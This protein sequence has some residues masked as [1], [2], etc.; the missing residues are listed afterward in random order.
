MAVQFQ[1]KNKT[2]PYLTFGRFFPKQILAMVSDRSL[3]FSR[4]SA[5]PEVEQKRDEFFREH[6]GMGREKIFTINQVHGKQV[7]SLKRPEL[8]SYREI[9]EA[10]GIIT[11][12]I[13]LPLAIRTADCLSLF[14]F[15]P[16]NAVIAL[17]HAGWRGTKEGI[18]LQALNMMNNEWGSSPASL[19]VAL[20]P[21]LRSCCYRV[22]RE[23][24][25][26]FPRET[27]SKIDGHYLDLPQA[28]LNQLLDHGIVESN[29][30]DCAI[31]T[32]CDERFFSHRREG[33]KTGRM[34]S[35]MMLKS[36]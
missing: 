23:F 19:K 20:G 1:S 5:D 15:D 11:K 24:K 27:L 35:L 36:S 26:Y 12:E 18:V 9:Q 3:N 28:N 6:L 14:I 8:N 31:C 30:F 2:K 29:I 34:I 25:D 13:G 22:G 17:V 16:G 10:D 32:C 21:C 7:V 4:A 33:E